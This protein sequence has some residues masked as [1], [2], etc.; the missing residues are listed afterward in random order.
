MNLVK[1][2]NHPELLIS[3]NGDIYKCGVRLKNSQNHTYSR[4][5]MVS[6][7][8]DG[9]QKRLSVAKLVCETFIKKAPLRDDEYI[10][11]L[12][13]NETNVNKD[14][15]RIFT[16]EKCNRGRKRRKKESDET[17]S[18]WMNGNAELFC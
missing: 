7:W 1:S 10:D 12:D 18:T 15:L 9:K 6:Y 3:E 11:Y 4:G 16:L 8:H 13:G 5:F 2:I 17:Y 14:N